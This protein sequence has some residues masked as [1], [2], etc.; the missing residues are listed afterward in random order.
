MTGLVEG[1]L[2]DL[3]E[4]DDPEQAKNAVIAARLVVKLAREL[5]SMS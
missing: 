3:P 4:L 1:G 5:R 2:D